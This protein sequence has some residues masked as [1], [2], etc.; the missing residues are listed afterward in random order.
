MCVLK[1]LEVASSDPLANVPDPDE[2]YQVFGF[3]QGNLPFIEIVDK[4]TGQGLIV[5]AASALGIAR[6]L[7]G[8]VLSV[9]GQ[10]VEK[11]GAEITEDVSGAEGLR[12]SQ[13]LWKRE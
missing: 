12:W 9:M 11:A 5:D 4:E 1:G 3:L 6:D 7:N 10:M 2:R 13:A 8:Q